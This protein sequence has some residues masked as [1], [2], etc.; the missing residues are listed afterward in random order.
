MGN[1]KTGFACRP[2]IIGAGAVALAWLWTLQP[3]PAFPQT[4]GA[5]SFNPGAAGAYALAVQ[6]DG[7]VLVGGGFGTLAGQPCNGFGRLNA[8]GTFDSSF[9]GSASGPEGRA[10]IVSSI[11]VQADGKILAGG[12][13]TVLDGQPRS[14]LGRL[15]ADGT[16][17]SQFNPGVGLA[18]QGPG[19]SP[20][21][22]VL[23]VQA[24]G[25]I[26]VGGTFTSLAD[27]PCT[28]LGRLNPS[29]TLDTSFAA[30]NTAGEAL[31]L[32]FQPD[33]KILVGG[34]VA[35]DG[36]QSCGIGRLNADGSWD[37]QFSPQTNPAVTVNSIA[38]QTDGKILLGGWFR[39]LDG[40][41]RSNIAR[42]NPD[43][44][45]DSSFN[46]GANDEVFSLVVQAD[47]Q[48]L[49][50]GAFRTLGG[51]PRTYLGRLNPDGTADTLFNPGADSLVQALA[52]QANGNILVGGSF[53]TLAG[54]ARSG[55]G[56]L[57]NTET[58]TQALSYDGSTIT[59]LR[60]GSSPEVWRTL[61][62]AS[63]D[64]VNLTPLG[65]GSRVPGGWQ[66]A[67]ASVPPS[68]ALVALGFVA[69]GGYDA[70]GWCV[71]T[72]IG[73]P[74]FIGLPASR[75]NSATTT[76]T[77][78]AAAS[79][80]GPLAF[81]WLKDG[82]PL[83]DGGNVSGAQTT[84]LAL[85]DV[86]HTDAGNYSVAVSNAL[87][88][89]TSTVATLTVIEPDIAAQPA[90]QSVELGQSAA[91]AVEAAG[92]PPFTYQWWKDGVELAGDTSSSLALTNASA[93]SAGNYWVVV[94]GPYG[95]VTSAVAELTVN[96]PTLDSGFKTFMP[97][98]GG[99]CALAL[100]PD[101]K[102]LTGSL[103]GLQRLNAD[104]TLEGGFSASVAGDN[105]MVQALAVQPDGKL[106]VGGSFAYLDGHALG[107]IG[108]LNS[109][110]TL[111]TQFDPAPTADPNPV[112]NALALEP[113]GEIVVA[114]DFN[115]LAGQKCTAIGLLNPDGSPDNI[116]NS[117]L[118]GGWSTCVA[119]E[120]DG[121]ILEA[122]G[123]VSGCLL[124]DPLTPPLPVVMNADG[125]LD[126][127]F[128]GWVG[129]GAVC[130]VFNCLVVQP[131][132]KILMGGFFDNVDGQSCS[133]LCRFNPDGTL[134]AGFNPSPNGEVCSLALQADGKLLVGGI[135]TAMDGQSR[136]SLARLNPDGT[137]DSQFNPDTDG[138]AGVYSLALQA[139]GKTLVGADFSSP[140][141]QAGSGY[142]RLNNLDAAAQSL[143]YDGS[144]I[145]WLRGG[146]S[147]EVWC[148]TFEASTNGAVWT[149]LGQGSRIPGGWQLA[150]V[151]VP[152]GG[153]I[154]ARGYYSTGWA[155]ASSSLLE[156]LLSIPAPP[157]PRILLSDGH[158]GFGTN[159]FGFNV[160]GPAG[161]AV[162]VDG[163]GNLSDWLPLATNT[164]GSG[165]FYFSDPAANEQQRRFYRARVVP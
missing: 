133:N 60:G 48:I 12:T 137:L 18:D 29:G 123:Y 62:E 39:T 2:Q 59:W 75:T 79:G 140:D 78:N 23:A 52:I 30:E 20:F 66:L 40:Q 114:G 161:Q 87:G 106:L 42:L 53:L 122:G 65:E 162:A 64:G 58:A 101:G 118:I 63:T 139:D 152:P 83:A 156:T 82:A 92:T 14:C 9:Y 158:F 117:V 16:L 165:P 107:A 8:D 21:V 7:K 131:D 31:S 109:D 84:A 51:Q 94:S 22:A 102:I 3:R 38:V 138:Y 89:V 151:L 111:D 47:G 99:L 135:F 19:A 68:N 103:W 91:F 32:A 155:N 144:T 100:Q 61:F 55:L 95:S 88:S 28:N 160:S 54:V 148:T 6:P 1:M 145:T 36:G 129:R 5:D 43:G 46:P 130:N 44:T 13:F 33:G 128:T 104:G 98:Y 17:D 153:T 71:E 41:P 67:A 45:V 85:G 154:R 115:T 113:D 163:S 86:L 11:E 136:N 24:D 74:V 81:H 93:G 142:E 69:G 4:P 56:R 10:C 125:S 73:R 57:T 26:L 34:L 127:E 112:V 49:V 76:A 120:A 50:G 90:S 147:P 27:Q 108:R 119:V 141:G 80:T 35:L 105:E 77:F 132:G 72:A 149:M 159:G 157:A 150:F 25:K 70:S 116:F 134:D 124:Q 37:N 15:N 110:A 164:L 126:T 97:L 143:A 121:K 146:S 96:M